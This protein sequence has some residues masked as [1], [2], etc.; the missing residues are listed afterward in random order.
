MGGKRGEGLEAVPLIN[1][2]QQ[3][4]TGEAAAHPV[5]NPTENIRHRKQACLYFIGFIYPQCSYLLHH[6]VHMMPA[7]LEIEVQISSDVLSLRLNSLKLETPLR[8]WVVWSVENIWSSVSITLLS[9]CVSSER[10]HCPHLPSRC[11]GQENCTVAPRPRPSSLWQEQLR[12]AD[13]GLLNSVEPW[14]P[15]DM[16]PVV[17]SSSTN[18]P[19]QWSS[20]L[21]WTIPDDKKNFLLQVL[22]VLEIILNIWLAKCPFLQIQC[23]VGVFR[24]FN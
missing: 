14:W 12:A 5:A 17:L 8:F 21:P 9:G 3:W 22:A 11:S 15:S 4:E 1:S 23:V 24:A 7:N 20:N 6:S 2:H 18:P 16:G 13:S 19:D 10:S